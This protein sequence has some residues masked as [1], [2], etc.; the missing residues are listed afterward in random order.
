[1]L[2][3]IIVELKQQEPTQDQKSQAKDVILFKNVHFILW[4]QI[5]I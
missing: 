3:V 2:K 5:I 1:M 4:S